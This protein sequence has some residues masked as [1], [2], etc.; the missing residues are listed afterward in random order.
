MNVIILS[1]PVSD[2]YAYVGSLGTIDKD[3]IRVGGV[4]FDFDN[5]WKVKE[6]S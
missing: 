2:R 4:W 3:K 6:V 1:S 5:R